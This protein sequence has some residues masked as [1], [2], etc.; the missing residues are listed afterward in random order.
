MS[1]ANFANTAMKQAELTNADCTEYT[2][3]SSSTSLVKRN[4]IENGSARDAG[5]SNTLTFGDLA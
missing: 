1:N 3:G 4:D 5:N 2:T